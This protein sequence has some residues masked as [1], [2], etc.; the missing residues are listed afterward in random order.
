MTDEKRPYLEQLNIKDARYLSNDIAIFLSEQSA[1]YTR[2]VEFFKHKLVQSYQDSEENES[3][4]TPVGP[5]K[6]LIN[7]FA[8]ETQKNYI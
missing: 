8:T 7:E 1:D 2:F 5:W 4:D 3:L 6:E